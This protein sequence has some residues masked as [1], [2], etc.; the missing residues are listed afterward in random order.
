M[1][2]KTSI[3]I[4]TPTYN[5]REKLERLYESLLKQT[6]LMFDWIIVDDGS[7]DDTDKL[8][9]KWIK[10]NKI[11]IS[12][13][14]QENSGKAN[15]LK[16]AISLCQ[17]KWMICI[18]SDDEVTEI[19]I[20]MMNNDICTNSERIKKAQGLI[21]PQKIKNIDYSKWVPL[22]VNY[23]NIM[24]LKY[25]YNIRE[26]AILFK[27]EKLKDLVFPNNSEKFLSEEILYNQLREKGK[28][29]VRNNAFYVSEYQE[30]GLTN[31]IF[32]VWVKN[33]NNTFL[34]FESRYAAIRELKGI[35]KAVNCCKCI[36]NYNAFCLA[37]K[38]RERISES[39]SVILSYLMWLP[40]ILVA[41]RRY[42]GKC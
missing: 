33:P 1:E 13:Y 31:N 29:F 38:Q 22:G 2:I 16:R 21:Y 24:D 18:D 8:V 32:N 7:V 28:F 40:S 36:L 27:V 39:P 23:I 25:I 35:P 42:A 37:T 15:A 30:N 14:F 41:K 5:R 20:E 19:A 6:N 4:F 26:S 12:Y 9:N 3:T 17:T 11:N 34:L 10:Q